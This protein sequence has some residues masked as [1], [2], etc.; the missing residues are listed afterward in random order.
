MSALVS[1]HV[2]EEL[3]VLAVV[4][5]GLDDFSRVSANLFQIWKAEN[6]VKK[7]GGPG[8]LF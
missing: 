7:V 1:A 6:V 5:N 2:H 3:I 4:I 8:V